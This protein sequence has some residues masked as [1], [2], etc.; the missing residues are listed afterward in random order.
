MYCLSSQISYIN[1]Q[2]VSFNALK[3]NLYMQTDGLDIQSDDCL[4]SQV[5]SLIQC[6]QV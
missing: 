3:I 1:P 5:D 4:A 6:Y 2:L